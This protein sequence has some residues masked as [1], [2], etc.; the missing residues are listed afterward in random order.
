M[1][2]RGV[3]SSSGEQSQV[4]RRAFVTALSAIGTVVPTAFGVAQS[5]MCGTSF[6]PLSL[7][8]ADWKMVSANA[9]DKE[10]MRRDGEE[11]ESIG[12][13]GLYWYIKETFSDFVLMVD[14]K[15]ERL[16]DNSGVFIRTPGPEPRPTAK[17]PLDATRD[18]GLEIQI[19]ERGFDVGDLTAGHPKKVTGA[20]YDLQAPF[21]YASR[22]VGQWNTFI[23]GAKGERIWV[24]LNGTL[25]NRYRSYRAPA[26]YLALQAF[27]P[28]SHVR[29]RR[30]QVLRLE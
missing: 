11:L 17:P 1:D 22:P 7:D 25:V 10:I 12:G 15:T 30:L 6:C 13:Y 16:E 5:S 19:D 2:I 21:A 18:E 28:Q 3:A 14:W 9:D 8:P 27:G 23:I 20:I 24:A 4:S 29:F 26:G